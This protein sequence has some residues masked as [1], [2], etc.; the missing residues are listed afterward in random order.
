MKGVFKLLVAVAAVAISVDASAQ[1]IVKKRI[2][3]YKESGNVVIAEASTTLAVDVVVEHEIFTPGVYARY[4]QKLLGTRASLVERDEYRIVEA[5]VAIIEEPT[6]YVS[7]DERPDH[8]APVYMGESPLPVDRISGAERTPEAAAKVAAEQILSLR[9]ARLDLIT[10][11]FGEG[12]Y[13][14]GLESA[15]AEISRLEREYLELFYGKRSISTESQRYIIPVSAEQPTTVVARFS[16]EQG[17]VATNDLTGD[18]ILVTITPSDMNYPESDI[19]GTVA[20]RYANNA[21]VKV[22]FGGEVIACRILPLYEFGKTVMFLQ[23]K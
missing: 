23:P 17:L 9:R 4:A 14:G 12:V 16:A 11:E 13:G 22:A 5:D 19:K 18:I 1:H 21:E 20:Y 15:L 6:H 7:D 8:N 2:G 10:G 3:S